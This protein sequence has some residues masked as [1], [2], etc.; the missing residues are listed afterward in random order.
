[1][2]LFGEKFEEQL[3]KITSAKQKSKS[4]FTRLQRKPN[5]MNQLVNPVIQSF[6]SGPLLN[7]QQ[8]GRG[9][10]SYLQEE[11]EVSNFSQYQF[12]Q[13]RVEILS[14]KDYPHIHPVI[15][16]LLYVENMQ[17]FR[18]AGRLQYFLK[19]WEKLTNDP[20]ILELVKGYQIPFLSKPSQTAPSSL[21]DQ[22]NQEQ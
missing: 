2:T 20:F 17:N 21:V 11:E 3:S 14:P 7:S 15:K 12:L 13:Q 16:R 8:R 18:P 5:M 1:M 19:S 10:A 9:E 4:I 22:E 6:R